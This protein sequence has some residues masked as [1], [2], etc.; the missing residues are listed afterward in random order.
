M[1]F[2]KPRQYAEANIQQKSEYYEYENYDHK[3]GDL[4]NYEVLRKIGRGKYSEVFEGV[5]L[6]EQSQQKV[7]IK[8]LNPVR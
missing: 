1:N 7:V 6:K 2:K 8:I 5:N 3:L 4:S